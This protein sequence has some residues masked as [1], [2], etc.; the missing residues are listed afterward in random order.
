MAGEIRDVLISEC[1]SEVGS[2]VSLSDCL[3][4]ERTA[5]PGTSLEGS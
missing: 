5:Y 4:A 1:S 2:A 3:S